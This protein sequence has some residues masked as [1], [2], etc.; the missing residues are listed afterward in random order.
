MKWGRRVLARQ[1]IHQQPREASP[2]STQCSVPGGDA[3][4]GQGPPHTHTHL[5]HRCSKELRHKAGHGGERVRPLRWAEHPGLGR[6]EAAAAVGVRSA[7]LIC[8]GPRRQW[9]RKAGRFPQEA[10]TRPHAPH[11]S[12]SNRAGDSA[13]R[14]T[15]GAKSGVLGGRPGDTITHTRSGGLA[16]PLTPLPQHTGS[17]IPTGPFLLSTGRHICVLCS[18]GE[19]HYSPSL[20]INCLLTPTSLVLQCHLQEDPQNKRMQPSF[21]SFRDPVGEQTGHR[22]K[23]TGLSTGQKRLTGSISQQHGLTQIRLPH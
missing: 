13:P 18:L 19:N 14:L 20:L 6:P 21:R 3:G 4:P 22:L 8:P 1:Q 2:V 16:A 5:Q 12:N 9:N 23:I 11:F 17:S 7:F 15:R 10:R